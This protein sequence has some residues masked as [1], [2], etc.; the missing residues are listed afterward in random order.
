MYLHLPTLTGISGDARFNPP[1][2][3]AFLP[4]ELHAEMSCVTPGALRSHMYPYTGDC[5]V[6]RFSVPSLLLQ[7][8]PMICTLIYACITNGYNPRYG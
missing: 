7:Q 1:A 2:E 3:S 6:I 5:I 4:F 8:K